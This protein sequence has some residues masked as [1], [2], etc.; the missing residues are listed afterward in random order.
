MNGPPVGAPMAETVPAD[1]QEKIQRL[2][3]AGQQLQALAQQRGQLDLMRSESERA[4]K[5]LE[6][7]GEDAPVYRSVGALLLRDD[8]ATALERLSDE[9]DTLEIRLKRL[10][11][12]EEH[13]AE[14][15]EALQAEV[16]KAL[17]A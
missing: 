16:Q 15:F 13:L 7:L 12:Q 5:A 4:H 2:Q 9:K 6:T 17:G 14:Q 8:R 10:K 1:I 3:A 11:Q